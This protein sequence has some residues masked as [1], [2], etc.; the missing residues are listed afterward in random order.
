ML[1]LKF[2]QVFS[3]SAWTEVASSS[4]CCNRPPGSGNGLVGILV[5]E[6]QELQQLEGEGVLAL[7]RSEI[8]TT[9]MY[10]ISLG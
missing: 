8:G 7:E 6:I 4:E 2:R 5:A 3:L 10:V 9:A 1:N